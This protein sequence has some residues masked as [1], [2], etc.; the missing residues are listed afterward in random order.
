LHDAYTALAQA[1][2]QRLSLL[3][4]ADIAAADAALAAAL[5]AAKEPAAKARE[6][7]ERLGAL[8]V[9]TPEMAGEPPPSGHFGR[10]TASVAGRLGAAAGGSALRKAVRFA[11]Y[12]EVKQIER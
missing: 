3:I 2:A 6:E 7:A 4:G 12:A 1:A 5:A 11:E 10:K 8:V 9:T